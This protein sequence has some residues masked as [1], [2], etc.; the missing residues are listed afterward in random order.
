MITLEEAKKHQDELQAHGRRLLDQLAIEQ[1]LAKLGDVNLDG[2]FLYGLMVKPDID[3]HIYNE[4][5][6]ITAVAEV[7]RK[8]MLLPGAARVQVGNKFVKPPLPGMPRGIY[9]G[10]AIFFETVEWSFD[11]WVLSR[12][13]KMDQANFPVGWADQLS[14][15]QRDNIILLKYQLAELGRYPSEVHSADVYR[16][17]KNDRVSTISELDEWRKT[18]PFY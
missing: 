9:L 6:D 8:F 3:Y 17:V 15:S 7:A 14:E 18:H 1:T 4:H 2:S 11:I 10:M 13:E 5:P 16:A 12:E